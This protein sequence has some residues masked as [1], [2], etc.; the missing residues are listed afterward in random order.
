[1]I[2]GTAFKTDIK[3]AKSIVIRFEKDHSTIDLFFDEDKTGKGHS[4]FP[5][6]N[7]ARLLG[8]W[9]IFL[10]PDQHGG[11]TTAMKAIKAGDKVQFTTEDHS[12]EDL[13]NDGYSSL[14]L[15]MRIERESASGR[16]S[17]YFEYA[18][19]TQTT[20]HSPNVQKQPPGSYSIS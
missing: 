10:Y 8:C 17:K 14:H 18:I 9:H 20:K 6:D 7:K 16:S 12:T 13:R 19:D 11:T 4:T 3:T 15:I 5:Y 1:M 2:I